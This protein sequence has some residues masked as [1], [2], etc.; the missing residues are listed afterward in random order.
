M[1]KF[2]RGMARKQ[3]LRVRE[4]RVVSEKDGSWKWSPSW[5]LFKSLFDKGVTTYSDKAVGRRKFAKGAR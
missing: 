4:K 1:A 5:K 3:W 2:M